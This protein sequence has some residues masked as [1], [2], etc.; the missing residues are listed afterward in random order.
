VRIPFTFAG[1]HGHS[2]LWC[3]SPAPPSRPGTR[4]PSPANRQC[5]RWSRPPASSRST[6]VAPRSATCRSRCL[7]RSSTPNVGSRPARQLRWSDRPRERPPHSGA[8]RR[9]AAGPAGARR[10]GLRGGRRAERLGLTH[11]AV[12]VIAAASFVGRPLV[13][14]PLDRLR[15]EHGLPPGLASPCSGATW[16]CRRS[17]PAFATCARR[18]GWSWRFCMPSAARPGGASIAPERR[19]AWV[20][21]GAE[22]D[23]YW[24]VATGRFPGATAGEPLTHRSADFRAAGFSIE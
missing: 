5:S 1:G 3:R 8:V 22:H 12:L 16:S 20:V 7:C 15:S 2:V 11:A 10:A 18:P 4:S 17:C 21:L 23:R 6:R 14:E 9:V 24:W 19:R 13:A